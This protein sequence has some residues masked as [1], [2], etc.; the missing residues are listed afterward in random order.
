MNWKPTQSRR[1][2]KWVLI[3]KERGEQGEA[4]KLALQFATLVSTLKRGKGTEKK[5]AK[6]KELSM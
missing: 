3:C 2:R 4:L 6:R 1:A 5:G